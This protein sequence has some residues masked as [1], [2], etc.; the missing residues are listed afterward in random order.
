[1]SLRYTE[2]N[3]PAGVEKITRTAQQLSLN[4]GSWISRFW[5]LCDGAMIED[6]VKIYSTDEIAERQQTYEIAE[7]F[8]GYLMIGDDSGGRLILVDRSAIE[9]FYLLGSGCPSI[10]D[11]LAFSSMDA[12]IKDVVG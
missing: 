1:M 12:L 8:P 2:K 6:L 9:R 11:G 7:Y 10:T 5:S 3:P 4:P